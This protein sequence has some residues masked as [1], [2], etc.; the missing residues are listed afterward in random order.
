LIIGGLGYHHD[1]S[2]RSDNVKEEGRS[3]RPIS[4]AAIERSAI[5]QLRVVSQSQ[6]QAKQ[7]SKRK[8]VHPT[9]VPA[10]E[11]VDSSS[12]EF[13]IAASLAGER[14]R[15]QAK[16][17]RKPIANESLILTQKQRIGNKSNQE[18]P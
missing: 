14:R 1:A 4:T 18:T 11:S 13:L 10:L 2:I 8:R 3:F 12:K 6:Q 5:V 9:S 17:E 7:T 15:H 16:V